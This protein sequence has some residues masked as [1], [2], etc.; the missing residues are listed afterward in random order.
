MPA[1][2]LQHNT[3]QHGES[4]RFHYINPISQVVAH[5]A[6][7]SVRPGQARKPELA[8]CTTARA[9]SW[10]A[11]AAAK[12]RRSQAPRPA[13]PQTH[14]VS[15]VEV[16]QLG[17]QRV[18]LARSGRSEGAKS[19]GAEGT[20]GRVGERV[21]WVLRREW[22]VGCRVLRQIDFKCALPLL[23]ASGIWPPATRLVG[24]GL[25][26]PRARP[27]RHAMNYTGTDCV[28]PT[29]GTT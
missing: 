15:G 20:V 9:A 22:A 8:A 5:N 24:P 13:S 29:E 7:A 19:E 23:L 16:V 28:G 25:A 11:A 1:C 3:A 21:R 27:F 12:R 10:A 17:L 14:E 4:H 26:R 6:L 2:A 18:H